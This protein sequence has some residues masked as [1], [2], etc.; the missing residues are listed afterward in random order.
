[1]LAGCGANSSDYASAAAHLRRPLD[2][3]ASDPM[4]ELVR[5]AT[6]AANGHNTQPWR[7]ERTSAGVSIVPDTTRRTPVVDPDDHHLFV[8]LG[9]A[10][11]NLLISA[12]SLGRTG[13]VAIDPAGSTLSI[14]LEAAATVDD[15][16]V[17]AIPRRQCTRSEYDG[18]APSS[19]DLSQLETAAAIEGVELRLLT[20]RPEI[21]AVRDYVVDGNRAQMNDP[22][23][24]QELKDWIRFN[25]QS[26]IAS[27]DGLYAA[28]SGNPTLPGWIAGAMFSLAFTVDAETEKYLAQMNTS[29]GVAVF[30]GA[31]ATPP[32]WIEVGRA[33]QRFALQATL[34]GLKHAFV[35][36]PVEVPSIRNQFAT[37]LG[38][39]DRRP[40]LIIRFGY[41]PDLPFSMR[42]AVSEVLS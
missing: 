15:S 12:P 28:S 26:A 22:A 24:V 34:L 2:T 8:G 27:G 16:L 33:Y 9:A 40:D 19:E 13:A 39:G 18:R 42:R 20:A 3:S 30:T 41:A 35:N 14:A 4:P 6:L 29:A 17:A 38:L 37:H 36:Q 31:T 23:F 5:F 1:M 32:S 7:F 21:D 25:P 10:A 11:E